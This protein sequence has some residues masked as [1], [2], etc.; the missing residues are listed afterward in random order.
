MLVAAE[1]SGDALGA[2]L[3]DSLKASLGEG[4]R[5]VGVGGPA[6]AAAGIQSPF[7]IAELSVLGLLEGLRAYPKVVH[8]ADETAALA[9]RERPDAVVLIDSWGFTLRVARRLRRLDPTLPLIKY[10]GPQVW[11]SRPGRARVLAH[12]VDHLLSIHRFDAPFFEQAG[13]PTTFV[14]NPVLSRDL[15]A[16]DPARLRRHIGAAPGQ[17]L[18]LLLPGSRRAE[19]QR[20]MPIYGEVAGRLAASRPSLQFVIPVAESVAAEV[21]QAVLTWRTRVHLVRG[22]ALKYDAMRAATV[23]LACSGTVTTEL[24]LAQCPMVVTYQ[25]GRI[26]YFI[27]KRI[28]T[29]KYATLFNIAAGE[30]VAPELL[31]DDG[32]AASLTSAL[33]ERLDDADLRSRQTARQNDALSK[34]GRGGPNPSAAAA[35]AVLKILGRSRPPQ[36]PDPAPTP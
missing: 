4:V 5:F 2:A 8:R 7:D 35:D 27:L 34:M 30:A 10:V 17:P 18:L 15:S 23:A 9:R 22:D 31:Q 26:T 36:P 29:T 14:G 19:V 33:A 1:P 12:H 13:L 6:M 32:D 21:E 20:L 3:A 28:L 16:A 11:A 25:V 24:A